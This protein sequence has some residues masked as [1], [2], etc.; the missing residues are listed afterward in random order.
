LKEPRTCCLVAVL[1]LAT[2]NATMVDA[3]QWSPPTPTNLKVL[4]KDVSGRALVATMRGFTQGLGGI[5]ATP[6][7]SVKRRSPALPATVATSAH[8]RAGL[9]GN[10]V[11]AADTSRD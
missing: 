3:Q 11:G 5:S 7:R 6:L 8:L 2:A 1:H 10:G 4:E 9:T